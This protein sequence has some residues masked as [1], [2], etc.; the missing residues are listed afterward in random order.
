MS[1]ASA[2]ILQA[3]RDVFVAVTSVSAAKVIPADDKGTRPVKPYWTVKVTA[4]RSGDFGPAER[5]DNLDGSTPQALMQERRE[6]TISIQGF[7]SGAAEA[8]DDFALLIDSPASLAAQDT[9]AATL[10][11]LS[12]PSDVAQLLDTQ[13]EPRSLLELRAR[14]LYRSVPQTTVAITTFEL[15]AEIER[16]TDDP[17]PL[18]IDY[19]YP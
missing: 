8:L 11:V 12:G 19:V 17:D 1:S 10:M 5:V 3:V 7:G 6:A 13:I 15:E 9:A 4:A 18:T 14:Y 2:T 16:Y